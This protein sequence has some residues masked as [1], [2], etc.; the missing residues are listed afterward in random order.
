MTKMTFTLD[1]V[2]MG[3]LISRLRELGEPAVAIAVWTGVR[4]PQLQDKLV[5]EFRQWAQRED[6]E[7]S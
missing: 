7:G 6:A 3:R 5:E 2:E 4:T 1:R